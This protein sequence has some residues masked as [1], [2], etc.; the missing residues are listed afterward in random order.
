MKIT[1]PDYGNSIL[2]LIS[3]V[4]AHFGVPG[5][6]GGLPLL[7]QLLAK[8][9]K[10][11]VIILF[12]GMGSDFVDCVLPDDGF[13]RTH[14]VADLSSVYPCTTAAAT[15]TLM[16]GLSPLEHGWLGWSAWFREYGRIVDLFL[17][18][19]SFSGAAVIPSPAGQLL[20]Y[21]SILPQILQARPGRL[22]GHK[23]MPPFDP[24]GVDSAAAMVDRIKACCQLEGDQLIL[25]YWHEPDTLMHNEGP[26]SEAVRK[27]MI[28]YD[29]MLA[30]L[31]CE[32]PDT[33]LI[34][35]AD[36]GQ[37]EITQEIYLDEIPD[38]NDCLILPPSL[39]GR[40]ASLF[41]KPDRLDEFAKIFNDLFGSCFLLLTRQEVFAKEL[42][43]SGMPHRKVG[44]F[45]GDFLACAT[46][47]AMIRYHSLFNRPRNIFRGHHA[48]LLH[49]E[50]V[51]P[52]IYAEN[53]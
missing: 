10:N 38:L 3:S 39:E 37:V 33:R 14:K 40:A 53:R 41:V 7:D 11:T 32:L 44:D 28:A 31:C 51:V 49:E 1:F 25:A 16:S 8:P 20:A 36:H 45:V 4:L 15:T 12:D 42:F 9:V 22:Q 35:T 27:E 26:Y 34:I 5:R 29:Q 24:E 43:G 13:L 19:D 47:P 52:L 21:E 30:K 18:R 48:G 50:M 23:I 46:G 17:D 2:S 6:H